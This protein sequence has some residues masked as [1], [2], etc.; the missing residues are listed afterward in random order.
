MIEVPYIHNTRTHAENQH[1]VFLV[2]RAELGHDDVQS[3]LRRRVQRTVF[4]AH[5]VDEAEIDVA[6]GNRNHLFHT[7]FSHERH[8]EIEQVEIAGYVCLEELAQRVVDFGWLVGPVSTRSTLAAGCC[9]R[10]V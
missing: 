1:A 9:A 5:V 4:D 3:R 8:E 2:L 7:A 6:T 10:R